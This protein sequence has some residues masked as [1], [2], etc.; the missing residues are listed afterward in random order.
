[1]TVGVWGKLLA[2]ILFCCNPGKAPYIAHRSL[3]P[4]QTLPIV[5]FLAI[6][7]SLW[8]V[9]LK[10]IRGIKEMDKY[11]TLG[12]SAATAAGCGVIAACF[13]PYLLKLAATSTKFN[14]PADS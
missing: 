7:A 10:G 6:W 4:V 8:A 12:I 13:M 11:T 5:V 2:C 14:A 9:L 1:V 3:L